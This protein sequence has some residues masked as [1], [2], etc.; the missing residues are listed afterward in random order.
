VQSV[1]ELATTESMQARPQS[2][3]W[4]SSHLRL[5]SD[6]PFDGRDGRY[7]LSLEQ[8]LASEKGAVQRPSG[9]RSHR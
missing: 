2:D 5:H 3:E 6:E 4:W 7:L 9:K 8:H 1:Y